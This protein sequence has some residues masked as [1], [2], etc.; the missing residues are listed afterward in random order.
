[1]KVRIGNDIRLKVRLAFEDDFANILSAKAYFV[2]KTLKD[3]LA[4][5]Y[6]NKN[7]FIGRFPIEPFVDEFEPNEYNVNSC[8]S[9]PKYK[10]IVANQYNGFGVRPN[11]KKSAPIK[12]VNITEYCSKIARTTDYQTIT[13]MFPGEAQLYVGEYDLI[14]VAK[15]YDNEYEGNERTV[16]AKLNSVFELVEEQEDAV[17]NPVQ[18]EIVNTDEVEN[19]ADVY[20]VGG[21]YDN[22]SIRLN[23]ND[24]GAISIDVSPI[25]GWYEDSGTTPVQPEEPEDPEETETEVQN[26]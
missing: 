10:A 15:V 9:Y 25:S 6:Q 2:N 23:R 22:H 16:T 11:W 19:T 13:A 26:D 12:E 14:V 1:M 7:R 20:I 21:S 17:D 3:K 24:N 18:V 4:K 8:G 5:E